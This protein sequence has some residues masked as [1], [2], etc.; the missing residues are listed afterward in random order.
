M[1]ILALT[2]LA[3]ILAP[4]AA[5]ADAV[6]YYD[7]AKVH[8]DCAD[9]KA[10][11]AALKADETRWDSEVDKAGEE[12]K[13]AD[14]ACA[15]SLGAGVTPSSSACEDARAKHQRHDQLLGQYRDAYQQR[16]AG[17]FQQA[18]GRVKR[19]LPAVAKA[20]HLGAILPV[21]GA[22]YVAPGSDLTAEVTRR[23][24]AGEGKDDAQVRA[25]NER[26]RAEND[27]LKAAQAAA[28]PAAAAAPKK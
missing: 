14:A 13:K 15:K 7:V 18:E 21:G 5:R 23:L 24:D 9:C 25:E 6:G 16:A 11:A 27:R 17:D 1:R 4:A 26:L 3:A 20:R 19:I 8:A 10:A 12:A 28:A 22:V 2:A